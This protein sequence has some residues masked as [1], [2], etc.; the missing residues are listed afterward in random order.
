MV[1]ASI[2]DLANKVGLD[3]DNMWAFFPQLVTLIPLGWFTYKSIVVIKEEITGEHNQQ[4][5]IPILAF[6]YML[7]AIYYIL[8]FITHFGEYISLNNY[9]VRNIL[10]YTDSQELYLFGI[11]LLSAVVL[12]ALTFNFLKSFYTLNALEFGLVNKLSLKATFK[13]NKLKAWVEGII[14]FGAAFLFIVIEKKFAFSNSIE[15]SESTGFLISIGKWI[16]ALYLSTLLWLLLMNICLAKYD[17][18]NLFSKAWYTFSYIQFISGLVVGSILIWLGTLDITDGRTV[19]FSLPAVLVLG[20]ISS[21]LVVFAIV[22]N[23]LRAYRHG[24]S[25]TN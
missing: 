7:F 24:T 6:I 2:L 18:A 5:A 12:S 11:N 15:L 23:E 17:G 10:D 13:S 19:K 14:R 9:T 16:V 21:A 25:G 22:A 3:A 20:I 1:L 4:G 8:L